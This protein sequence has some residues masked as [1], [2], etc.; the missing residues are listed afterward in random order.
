MG[1][2]DKNDME[3]N[4]VVF[5]SPGT[6]VAEQD[7]KEIESWNVE[8]AIEMAK[9]IKQRHGAYPYGFYFITRGRRQN[10][11]DSR[12]RKTSGI[13]YLGGTVKTLED[14]KAENDPGNR[15]LISNMECNKW[16]R[17]IVTNGWGWTLPL[18]KG[19]IVLDIYNFE[20]QL[21]R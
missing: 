3:K 12:I 7:T 10:E 21:K 18:E 1:L 19:D 20:K 15:I 9:S 14:V 5:C 4:F 6:F 16:D 11:L 2:M 13:Y 17:V 8:E